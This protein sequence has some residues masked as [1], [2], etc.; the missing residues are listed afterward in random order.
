MERDTYTWLGARAKDI[1]FRLSGYK[2]GKYIDGDGF[3]L[4]LHGLVEGSDLPRQGRESGVIESIIGLHH[5]D[6]REV[7]MSCCETH[8]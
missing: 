2:G 1:W 4:H 5:F 6:T 3:F 7:S 8:R